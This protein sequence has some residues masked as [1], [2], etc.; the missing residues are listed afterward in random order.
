MPTVE[1]T[2]VTP[3]GYWCVQVVRHGTS[4][5]YRIT[6]ATTVVAERASLATV[7]RVLGDDF[8]KLRPAEPD[9][10]ANGTA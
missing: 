2:L 1:G 8:A 4:R 5:W 7:Q 9:D 10:A 3:D 6:H